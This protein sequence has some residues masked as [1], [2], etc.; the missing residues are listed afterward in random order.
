M[1]PQFVTLGDQ[2]ELFLLINKVEVY[3]NSLPTSRELSI[4]K[5]KL[6]EARLWSTQLPLGPVE[7]VDSST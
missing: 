6:Q 2:T 1:Q 3:V 7:L 5:T 4:V